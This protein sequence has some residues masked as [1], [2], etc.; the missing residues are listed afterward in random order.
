[1]P[2]DVADPESV[3][4]LFAA[5]R[6]EWG[7]V[8]L[9]VNNAG[10]FGPAGAVDEISVEADWRQVV[11]TNL[12]GAFLCARAA[13]ADDEGPGPAGR[14]DHQQRLD[15]RAHAAAGQRRLHRHQARA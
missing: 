11:D 4:D 5:A 6:G 15:L 7:R 12:T 14:P 9:L 10:T 8:D 1:M 13:V 2:T 3:A